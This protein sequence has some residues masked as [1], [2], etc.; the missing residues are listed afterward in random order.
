MSSIFLHVSPQFQ[1]RRKKVLLKKPS[2][3]FFS[4]QL[5]CICL[6][7]DIF[8]FQFSNAA[9]TEQTFWQG[10]GGWV[11]LSAALSSGHLCWVSLPTWVQ[12]LQSD[13]LADAEHSV[14]VSLLVLRINLKRLLKRFSKG[15]PFW[16]FTCWTCWNWNSSASRREQLVLWETRPS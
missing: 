13:T 4:F 14:Q 9:S 11:C 12:H 6:N 15:R 3:R 8:L 2:V 1:G 10:G 5:K 16:V 7:S